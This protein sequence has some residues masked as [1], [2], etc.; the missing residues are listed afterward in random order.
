MKRNPVRAAIIAASILVAATALSGCSPAVHTPAGTGGHGSGGT[1]HSHGASPSSTPI[2]TPTPTPTA[3]ATP[4]PASLGPLPANALFRITAQGIQPNGATVDLVQTVFAPTTGNAADTALLNKQCNFSGSPTWQSLFPGGSLV[5]DSTLTA[6]LDPTTPAFNTH[7]SIG[8]SFDFTAD[9]FSGAYETA[10]APCAPGY[11]GL[12]GTM[13]GVGAVLKSN[14]AHGYWGWASANA[15][16]GFFGDGNDPG[17]PNGGNG[18]TIV[19]NCAVQ[20]S[21]AA[22]SAAPTLAAWKTQPYVQ[23]KSC[24]Y[25]P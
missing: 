13:H 7:A 16:Y 23:S 2:A 25:T 17:D 3:T 10:Q 1:N 20:V 8:T 18:D 11:I 12:P 14:P 9:A 22:L 15:T 21:P 4:F 5:V 24:Y 19:K 6:T